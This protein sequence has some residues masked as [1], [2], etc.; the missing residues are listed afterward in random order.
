MSWRLLGSEPPFSR[1]GRPQ[2]QPTIGGSARMLRGGYAMSLKKTLGGLFAVTWLMAGSVIA[3][4]L[5]A[6]AREPVAPPA[7]VPGWTFR[8]TPYGWL[9]SLNGSQTVRGRSVDVDAS[10][11]DIVDNTIG[12]GG[13]LIA[14]MLNMEARHGRLALFGDVIGE[15]LTVERSGIRARTAAAGIGGA[16]GLALDMKVKMAIV[17]AGA[18]YEIGSFGHVAIDV[19]AGARYWRQKLELGLDIGTAANL[20]DLVIARGRALARS[21]SVDWVDAFAGLRARISLAPNHQLEFRG[22][23]GAGGSKLTWHALAAYAYDFKTTNGV[24]YS[25]VIGYKALYVD[26]SQGAGLS[27]YEFDMLQHGPV[28][29][30]SVRF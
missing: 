27:R 11:I 6:P 16:V 29:G 28:I 22:D 1:I 19:L 8:L 13:S 7:F 20:G 10:F 25:A 23:L 18:A 15:S 2:A 14:L 21:G 17:E 4:D 9:T 3:A 24:T 30:L 12:K 5:P 26:Y